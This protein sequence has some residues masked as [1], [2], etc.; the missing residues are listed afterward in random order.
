MIDTTEGPK[1]LANITQ[2]P[3]ALH[4]DAGLFL[5][6][7]SRCGG[8]GIAVVTALRRTG[9]TV[10]KSCHLV[11]Q[12]D[13][14]LRCRHVQASFQIRRGWRPGNLDRLPW[15]HAQGIALRPQIGSF[16]LSEL[17]LFVGGLGLTRACDFQSSRVGP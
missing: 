12:P 15:D 7:S 13:Q 6:Q 10:A 2:P 8:Y 14:G 16:D 4:Q 11:S 17:V 3:H 1:M 5:H 9:H